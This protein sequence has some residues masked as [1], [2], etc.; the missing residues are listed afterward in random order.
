MLSVGAFLH[1]KKITTIRK[2]LPNRP[3]YGIMSVSGIA[4]FYSSQSPSKSHNSS[5]PYSPPKSALL[6]PNKPSRLGLARR[7]EAKEW[8]AGNLSEVMD[9]ALQDAIRRTPEASDITQTMLNFFEGGGAASGVN[10]NDA[11]GKRHEETAAAAAL[12][13]K[14]I[15]IDVVKAKPDD[16]KGF[17]IENL[18]KRIAA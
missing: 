6:S 18:K 8:L 11:D 9:S 10:N 4:D 5:L 17:V 15:S 1:P 2:T 14:H 12:L 3:S 13:V 7:E 16:I